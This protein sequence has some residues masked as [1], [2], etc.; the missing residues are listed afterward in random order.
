MK[1]RFLTICC[2]L[3]SA[4]SF[5]M[6]M[7]EFLRQD[8]ISRKEYSKIS[9]NIAKRFNLKLLCDNGLGTLVDDD[10]ITWCSK[11]MVQGHALTIDD[12]RPV[13]LHAIQYLWENVKKEKSFTK[14]SEYKSE[15]FQKNIV[16][17]LDY[18]GMRVDLWDERNNRYLYPYLSQVVL[19][20]GKVHYY[21][22]SPE[23]QALQKP[24]VIEDLPSWVIGN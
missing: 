17:S 7:D 5:G 24:G 10:K 4:F 1:L 19:K 22:A 6:D 21:Y 15:Y 20:G 18:I 8:K 9:K 16:L 3:Q 13:M 23:N 14:Y 2:I 11:F 12:F